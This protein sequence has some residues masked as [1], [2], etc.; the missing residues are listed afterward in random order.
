MFGAQRG[1]QRSAERTRPDVDDERGVVDRDDAVE[2]GE[3]E[4]QA[5]VH[6]H[7][8]AADTAATCRRGDRHAGL[9][10]DPEDRGDVGGRRRTDDRSRARHRGVVGGPDHRQWPPIAAGGP[11]RVGVGHDRAHIFEPLEDRVGD[12][13]D[14]AVERAHEWCSDPIEARYDAT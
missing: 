9:V 7:A 2:I 6:R 1:L 13:G 14:G 3:V 12:V 5:A 8:R 11:D 10:A 4:H